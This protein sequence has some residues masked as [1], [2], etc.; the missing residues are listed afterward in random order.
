MSN[1]PSTDEDHVLWVYSSRKVSEWTRVAIVWQ[2][3]K[4]VDLFQVTQ[5]RWRSRR[6]SL[7]SGVAIS[8]GDLTIQK[9][10]LKRTGS[11]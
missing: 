3:R 7:Q 4:L 11:F 1:L 9:R 5:R 2:I 8:G 10:V 6:P